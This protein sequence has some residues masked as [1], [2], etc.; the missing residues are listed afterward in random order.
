MQRCYFVQHHVVHFNDKL[1]AEGSYR[2]SNPAPLIK[3]VSDVVWWNKGPTITIPSRDCGL[4]RSKY[5]VWGKTTHALLF[6]F[7]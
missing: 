1:L 4:L 7:G 2:K 6:P 5:G 3:G